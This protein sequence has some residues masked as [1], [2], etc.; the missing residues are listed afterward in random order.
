MSVVVRAMTIMIWDFRAMKIQFALAIKNN[1]TESIS[2]YF[3]T[4]YANKI[5]NVCKNDTIPNYS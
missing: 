1:Y 4:V 3:I 2:Y 5:I